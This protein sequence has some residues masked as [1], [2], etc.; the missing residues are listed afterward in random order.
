MTSLVL[1]LALIVIFKFRQAPEK[2]PELTAAPETASV[3]PAPSL[4][5]PV[6]LNEEQTAR[7]HHLDEGS[8]FFPLSF[9]YALKDAETGKPFIEVL[10]RFGLV[11]DISD[12]SALPVGL[13]TGQ[14]AS[15]PNQSLYLGVN[16]AACHSGKY[17][18]QGRAMVIDGA[19]NMLNFEALLIALEQSLLKT[20][21]SPSDL[22]QMISVLMKREHDPG[23]AGELF[24]IH[25]SALPLFSNAAAATDDHPLSKLRRQL[26]TGLHDAY[27]SDAAQRANKLKALAD[28]IP[29]S[30]PG[31]GDWDKEVVEHVQNAISG[32]DDD[33]AFIEEHAKRLSKLRKSFVGETEAGPGRADSFDAIWDLLV[34]KQ[35]PFAM[36]APVSIPHLFDYSNFKWIHWDGNT[37]T[38]LERDYAQAIALGGT[39]DPESFES[40]VIAPNVIDLELV[41]RNFTS[42]RW[43]DEIL[44]TIDQEKVTRGKQIFASHCLACHGEESLTPMETVGTDPQ[45]A[46][47]FARM[48]LDGKSYAEILSELGGAVVKAS[49]AAHGIDQASLKPIAHSDNPR[50]RITNAYHSRPLQGIWASPP[51]LHNGSVPTLWDLMSPADKRPK[52]FKVGREYDPE[53]V[54]INA[55]NQPDDGW[56]F[57]IDKKGNSNQGHEYGNDLS[58]KERWDLVEYLKTL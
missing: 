23:R 8:G 21:E 54:G 16:C 14:L 39:Y 26:E 10:P 28:A 12:P 27:H 11:P 25:P 19:P 2:T 43:P 33:L 15:A 41:A 1:L 35:Q 20:L 4:R 18:Y 45:R 32:F 30:I 52:T 47:N 7:W 31:S 13:T 49:L 38:V 9:F 6:G 56:T 58:N 55:V 34:Q 17:T 51:Y 42:P 53:K 3:T 50:W 44:G 57:N 22:F 5:I 36:T 46:G 24:E 48:E 29:D 40:S 37:S